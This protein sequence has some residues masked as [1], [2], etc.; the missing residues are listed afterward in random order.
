ES[1]ARIDRWAA[2]VAPKTEV[3]GLL[4]RSWYELVAR[5][6]PLRERQ[7]AR[8][9]APAARQARI[10]QLGADIVAQNAKLA[11]LQTLLLE[12]DQIQR[13]LLSWLLR[14]ATADGIVDEVPPAFQSADRR[15]IWKAALGDQ[16]LPSLRGLAIKAR[17][18]RDA[19]EALGRMAAQIDQYVDR[20]KPQISARMLAA[21]ERQPPDWRDT[22]LAGLVAG[23]ADGLL[24]PVPAAEAGLYPFLQAALTRATATDPRVRIP[25]HRV[26]ANI[27]GLRGMAADLRSSQKRLTQLAGVQSQEFTGVVDRLAAG[28][29]ADLRAHLLAEQ[30]AVSEGLEA[31]RREL[32]ALKQQARADEQGDSEEDQQLQAL[33]REKERLAQGIRKGL[34]IDGAD[35]LMPLRDIERTALEALTAAPMDWEVGWREARDRLESARAAVVEATA[36]HDVEVSLLGW[37]QRLEAAL[38]SAGRRYDAAEAAVLD[39]AAERQRADAAV[40]ALE[41]AHSAARQAWLA[42]Y[43]AVPEALRP[44]TKS[45]TSSATLD[46]LRERCAAW[47]AEHAGLRSYLDSYAGFII[48]WANRVTA[49]HAQDEADLRQIYIDNANVIGITCVQAGGRSFSQRYR[50]FDTVIID[51][52]SKATPPE[53]LLPML[54][55][56]KVVLVGDSRQLPPMVGPEALQDLAESLGIGAGDLAHLERSLYRDLFE[57]A[58]VPLKSWLT[59]QYRMHPQIMAAINQFYHNKLACGIPEPDVT[60]VHGMAPLIPESTHI[61]WVQTDWA[62]A[63]YE[64][65]V[66][67]SRQ[68]DKEV[69]I[70]ANLLAKMDTIWGGR[71][72]GSPPKEVGVITF[73]AAQEQ[74]LRSRLLNRGRVPRFSHLDLRLGTVDRFQGMERPVII[75]SLVCNNARRDIGFARE[76]ERINVAFSRA[77]ELLVIVG[78]RELFCREAAAADAAERYARVAAVVQRGG[79][80]LDAAD[81]IAS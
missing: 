70:I 74:A 25:E 38:E 73:Y 78:S 29:A 69:E 11:A 67:T 76:L 44:G 7:R 26:A 32:L 65:R 39:A 2:E 18:S 14:R 47:E 81:F 36:A 3:L 34:G 46:Q 5:E 13:G 8:R 50:N 23:T 59:D 40:A 1:A 55:G 57:R 33:N 49:R 27:V 19:A 77:Q 31:A 21:A 42:A 41:E 62:P 60:R 45:A 22:D 52:V 43:E 66:G 37:Q 61:A 6:Q 71:S 15:G 58:P 20:L 64:S 54:K 63:F 16:R 53:L 17:E 72:E 4:C 30:R 48:D 75:V 24:Y 68:N 56:A 80:M 10:S 12:M 28:L 9:A 35:V 51:E 79:G